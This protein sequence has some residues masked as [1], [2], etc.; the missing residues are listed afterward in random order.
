MWLCFPAMSS[1]VT[2]KAHI[3]DEIAED[4]FEMT[5]FEDFVTEE[6]LKGRSIAGLYPPTQEKSKDDFAV[7]RKLK[8]R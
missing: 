7:W 1:W 3:A 2:K 4:A 6:V 8:G 5:A